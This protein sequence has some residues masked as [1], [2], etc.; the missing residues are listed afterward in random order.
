[1]RRLFLAL[2]VFS[3]AVSGCWNFQG[4]IDKAQSRDAGTDLYACPTQRLPLAEDCSNGVDDNDDCLADCEDP[5]CAEFLACL[6]KQGQFLGYGNAYAKGYSCTNQT[7]TDLKQGLSLSGNCSG[8]CG[9]SCQSTLRWFSDGSAC[10]NNGPSQGT[11]SAANSGTGTDCKATAGTTSS[12]VFSLNVQTA[13]VTDTTKPGALQSTFTLEKRLCSQGGPCTTLKCAADT[14]AQCVAFRGSLASCPARFPM[15][16]QWFQSVT[17]SR[18]C[19]CQCMKNSN[20]CAI[21]GSEALLTT[22]ANCMGGGG[23]QATNIPQ[24]DFCVAPGFSGGAAAAGFAFS[25]QP[26]CSSVTGT[27]ATDLAAEMAA[28]RVQLGGA[29]T[30]CCIAPIQ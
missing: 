12:S 25:A 2:L 22:S 1:M 30:T 11:T 4:L 23:A 14:G 20:S 17:D 8:A 21:G 27:A 6:D 16:Q 5:Q 15:L 26:S 7:G 9:C 29:I 19:S 18:M 3:S 10:S 13:C 28:G 24:P